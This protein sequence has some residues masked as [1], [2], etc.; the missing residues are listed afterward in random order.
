MS[1]RVAAA[2]VVILSLAGC[3]NGTAIK[4]PV[5]GEAENEHLLDDAALAIR[6]GLQQQAIDNA[7]DPVI[8]YY[9][10]R[11]AHSSNVIYCTHSMPETVYYMGIAAANKQDAVALGPT[12]AQA[13]MLKAYALFD[14]QRY[15]EAAVALDKALKLSPENSQFLAELGAGYI[16]HKNWTKALETYQHAEVSAQTFSP[17][18]AKDYDLAR[19]WRGQ[20]FVLTELGKLDEA[21]ALYLKCLQLNPDDKRAANELKYVRNVREK[22]KGQ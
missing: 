15:D 13:Y 19:S 3:T 2:C 16:R 7:L 9:E 21:E 17:A 8:T 1:I 10:Q 11:Y 22:Q 5:A 20:G 18:A 12:W 6:G 4:Q 14:L